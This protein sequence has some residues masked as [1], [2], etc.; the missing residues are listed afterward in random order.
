MLL[1]RSILEGRRRI[2]G[3]VEELHL[4]RGVPQQLIVV[5][6]CCC[7]RMIWDRLSRKMVRSGERHIPSEMT[8]RIKCSNSQ[9]YDGYFDMETERD[10]N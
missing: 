5:P 3:T 1:C 8:N 2:P 4:A 9:S 7:T 10:P 6:A